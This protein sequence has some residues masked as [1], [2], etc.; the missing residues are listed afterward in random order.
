MPCRPPPSPHPAAAFPPH[1]GPPPSPYR[2]TTSTQPRCRVTRIV[3]SAVISA[4]PR[5]TPTPA[6]LLP[7]QRRHRLSYKLAAV[8]VDAE[9][10]QP[11]SPGLKAPPAELD[12]SAYKRH[13]R[14][15]SIAIPSSQKHL[16]TP[17]VFLLAL[18][19]PPLFFPQE[20][21]SPS[22][23]SPGPSRFNSSCGEHLMTLPYQTQPTTCP[24]PAASE[25]PTTSSR[26]CSYGCHGCRSRPPFPM[27]EVAKVE[28]PHPPV[29]PHTLGLENGGRSRRQLELE[30]PSHGVAAAEENTSCSV[31]LTF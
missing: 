14:P 4:T 17:L 30:L 11:Q 19:P 7:L 22:I 26:S 24:L 20:Q 13:P 2:A 9:R 8:H 1:A 23:S 29:S 25:L 6:S 3:N 21:T 27:P 5:C 31:P 28:P 18:I 12:L 15:P 16:T 10:P